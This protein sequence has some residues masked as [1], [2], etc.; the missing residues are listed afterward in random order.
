MDSTSHEVYDPLG[1]SVQISVAICESADQNSIEIYDDAIA[2]IE[3]PALVFLMQQEKTEHY[4]YR[5]VGWNKIM[6]IIAE[7]QDGS[8]IASECIIDPSKELMATIFEK[9]TQLL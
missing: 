5:S 1:N 9:G 8:F 6:M 7:K 4:Y 2:V 3:K